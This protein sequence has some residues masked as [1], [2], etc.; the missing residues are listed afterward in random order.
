MMKKIVQK[1]PLIISIILSII[2]FAIGS[3]FIKGFATIFSLRSILVLSTFLGIAAVGQTLVI[4]LGGIDLSIGFL[5]GFGNVVTAK[6]YGD[7]KSPLITFTIVIGIAIFIGVF[8]GFISAKFKIHPLIITLG[9]G[10][11][12]QG[13]ILLWTKGYPTGSAPTFITKFVSIGATVGSFPFPGIVL[14]WAIITIGIELFLRYSIFGR[15][16]YALGSNSLAAELALVKRVNISMITYATSSVFAA[17]D[18][19]LLLGFTGSAMATVGEDYLMLTIGAVVVGGTV[20]VGGKGNY[21]NTFIGS[22]ILIELT[23]VLR[24]FGLPD[25][26]IPAALGLIIILLV[27]IYGRELS[28]KEKM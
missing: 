12:I 24:G 27:S 3:I 18:G 14:F 26:L 4:L 1:Q 8:N 7:G 15:Q 20:M 17:L 23:T 9:V 21:I 5:I 6:L 2:I 16:L 13:A 19:I 25:Q 10:F 22:F 11:A 28:I